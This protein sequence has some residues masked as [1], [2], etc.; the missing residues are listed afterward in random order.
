[1]SEIKVTRPTNDA[2]EKHNIKTWS[3]WGCDVST[4][5]WEYSDEEIC[6]ILEGFVTVITEDG[7][8]V[9]IQKGDLVTFPKGMK[10]KWE[11]KEKINKVYIFR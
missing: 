3:P 8:K 2:L 11:V 9:D 10:C 1:M 6:Y 4:F 7:K 5:D